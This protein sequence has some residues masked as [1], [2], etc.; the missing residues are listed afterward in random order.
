MGNPIEISRDESSA[1][2]LRALASSTRDGRVVR[3]L[4]AIALVLEGQSR[5]EAARLNGMDRQTLRDWV[6]RYNDEG[7]AGLHPRA[8]PGR[9]GAL[10][11]EQM[12]ELRTMVLEGPDPDVDGVVRWRCAD[13][14][15]AIAARWSVTLTVRSVGRLL[16]RLDMTRLQPRPFHPKRDAA[17]QADFKKNPEPGSSS[18]A[19]IGGRQANRNLVSRRSPGRPEGE[20]GV[21]LGASWFAPA[22]GSRQP[23]RLCLHIRRHLP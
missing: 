1:A 21:H 5:A 7:V 11:D 3:R 20:P 10:T 18:L 8:I 12:E 22:D 16:Q 19:G 9:P 2:E 23:A 15:D 6:H 14:R 17:A 4:L 13:L